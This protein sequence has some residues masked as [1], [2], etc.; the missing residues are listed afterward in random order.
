MA[1]WLNRPEWGELLRLLDEF[2]TDTVNAL[3]GVDPN[4]SA[5]IAGY[6]A[7]MKFIAMFKSGNVRDALLEPLR[8]KHE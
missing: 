3:R 4:D 2:E 8:N 5:R 6:Q 7:G 1:D